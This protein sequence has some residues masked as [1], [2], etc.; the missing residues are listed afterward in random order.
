VADRISEVN[1]MVVEKKM[2]FIGQRVGRGGGTDKR[3]PEGD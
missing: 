2:F 3:E 1:K